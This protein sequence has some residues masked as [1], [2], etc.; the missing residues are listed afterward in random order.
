[1][2]MTYRYDDKAADHTRHVESIFFGWE[3][4]N[5]AHECIAAWHMGTDVLAHAY[6][7]LHCF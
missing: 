2:Q 1:M 7:A 6:K 5:V 4:C 3:T